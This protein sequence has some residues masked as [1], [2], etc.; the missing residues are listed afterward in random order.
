MI[1]ISGVVAEIAQGKRVEREESPETAHLGAL[2]PV[3]SPERQLKSGE[4][5]VPAAE[6]GRHFRRRGGRRWQRQPAGCM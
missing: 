3:G 4:C 6:R 1:E 5:G 2:A